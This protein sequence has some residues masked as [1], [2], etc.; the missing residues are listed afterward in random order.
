MKR[1]KELE[2]KYKELGE[3]IERL[4]CKS[5]ERWRADYA[6][7]YWY[8]ADNGDVTEDEDGDWVCDEHRFDIG[9]YF[10]TEEEAEK[11]LN[12]ILIYNKLKDLALR[13]N[14]G[15]PV[16]WG[17]KNINKYYIY[18]TCHTGGENKLT[19]SYNQSCKEFG[20]IYCLDPNFLSVALDEIGE[21]DLRK[22]FEE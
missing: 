19:W 9:N 16:D 5:T 20:N 3:E 2:K 18:L 14:K 10:K 4:K 22:L 21:E 8:I 17:N 1:L 15:E 7:E 11:V 12:K 13:L 6:G